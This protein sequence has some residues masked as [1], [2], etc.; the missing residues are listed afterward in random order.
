MTPTF[1]VGGAVG[2]V[3]ER[4]R[5]DLQSERRPVCCVIGAYVK[6]HADRPVADLRLCADWG[7]EGIVRGS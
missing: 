6:S 3:G 5:D 7:A 4:E 2:D 1:S